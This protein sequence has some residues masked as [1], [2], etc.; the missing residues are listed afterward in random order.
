MDLRKWPRR[1]DAES[2]GA[3]REAI[4]TVVGDEPL[5]HDDEAWVRAQESHTGRW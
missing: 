5:S 4:R 3:R 1:N 2:I